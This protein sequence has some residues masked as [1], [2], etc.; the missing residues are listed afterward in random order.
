PHTYM[1]D[2]FTNNAL[3]AGTT[4]FQIK[5]L[6]LYMVAVTGQT[7][8]DVVAR[9]QFWNTYTSANT[10]VFTGAAGTTVLVDL[11][12][13]TTADGTFYPI[14]ATL[15]VPVALT[16]GNGTSWGFAQNFQADSGSGLADT[17]D[18][19]SLI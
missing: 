8:T 6:R 12:P 18:L 19:T 1:G 14:D 5:T 7:Y 2:G 11:G 9:V 17:T 15:A 3:P 10:P 4:G 13:M 16:G